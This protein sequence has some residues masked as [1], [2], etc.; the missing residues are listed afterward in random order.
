MKILKLL[1]LL[2]DTV[3]VLCILLAAA[4][5]G[6]A[7]WDNSQVYA[8]ADNVRKKMLL[9]KPEAKTAQTSDTSFSRL[10]EV[11]P[12]ICAWLTLDHTRI[13]YPILQGK[14]NL[15]Y[16]NTDVYGNFALAG[17]IYLD[18]RNDSSFRDAYSL[19][20]GHHMESG[21]MFGDLDL[22]KD[23]SFFAQNRSGCLI[24]QE[25]TY[26]LEVF[27]VLSV[28]ASERMI[29]EITRVGTD[30]T[31]PETTALLKFVSTHALLVNTDV[32]DRLL[33]SETAPQI[34]GMSTCSSEF[35][36]ART[37]VLAVMEPR[38]SEN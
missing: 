32:A 15:S 21:R 35:T 19:L 30:D 5:S 12:D 23:K 18:S 28:P 34:L 25:R 8:S 20:Y 6:Y 1:N 13:D 2:L 27:A 33:A 7:L 16:I 22:Y 4:Y 14:D 10:M 11:N 29:F 38:L 37:V 24:L 3:I 26:R 17:S 36:D 31:V 9:L